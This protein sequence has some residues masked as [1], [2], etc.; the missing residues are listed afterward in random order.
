M[1]FKLIMSAVTALNRKDNGYFLIKSTLHNMESGERLPSSTAS[2]STPTSSTI[3]SVASSVS[4]GRLFHRSC[5]T[6]LYNQ[7]MWTFIQSS[8]G[9]AV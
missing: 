8:W 5:F 4:T 3:P 6:E 1:R 7:P 2:S 9:S